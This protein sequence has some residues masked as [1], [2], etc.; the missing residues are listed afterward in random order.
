MLARSPARQA[1]APAGAGASHAQHTLRGSAGFS[2]S[3]RDA[4][5]AAEIA[6][7]AP[8]HPWRASA[9]QRGPR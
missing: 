3:P 4:H 5:C 7:A 2:F 8:A 9:S 1:R 6:R